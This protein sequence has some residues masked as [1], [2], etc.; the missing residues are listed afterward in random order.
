MD[1]RMK[2]LYNAISEAMSL[3]NLERQ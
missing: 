1:G 3:Q 2:A